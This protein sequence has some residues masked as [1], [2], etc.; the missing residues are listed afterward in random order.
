[1][2]VCMISQILLASIFVISQAKPFQP[3]ES[4]NQ[5]LP[6]KA[7]VF[8]NDP[9][10]IKDE[11]QK[12]NTTMYGLTISL[13]FSTSQSDVKYGP[14]HVHKNRTHMKWHDRLYSTVLGEFSLTQKIRSRLSYSLDE[15]KGKCC[16][17]KTRLCLVS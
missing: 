15:D 13:N 14:K 17:C 7:S 2:K 3:N 11:F 6:L 8:L 5:T 9:E 1:M 12:P 10:S 16:S 4:S